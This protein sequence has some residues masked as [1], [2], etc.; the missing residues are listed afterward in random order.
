L[1]WRARLD[2]W[3]ADIAAAVHAHVPFQRALIGFE[4]DG[5]ADPTVDRRYSAALTP[6]PDGWD[7]MPANA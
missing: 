6:G 3:L 1:S 4:V 2:R 7:Y 5:D